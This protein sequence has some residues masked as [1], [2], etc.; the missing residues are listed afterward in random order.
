MKAQDLMTKNPKTCEASDTLRAVIEIMRDEDCGLVPIIEG[1]GE[2]RVVGVVTDRDAALYL[3]G[4]DRKPSEVHASDVMKSNI[5]SCGPDA[6]ISEITRMMETAQVRRILVCE[7][8]RLL[9]VISTADVARGA[10]RNE[11][12]RVLEGVSQPGHTRGH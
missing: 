8:E 6:D 1:N 2:G 10:A 7:G 11:A 3:G 5:V 9:G 4:E 12:G